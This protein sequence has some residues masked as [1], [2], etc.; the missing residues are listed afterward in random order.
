MKGTK[1]YLILFLIIL[2]AALFCYNYIFNIYEVTYNLSSNS[3]FADNKSTVTISTI[4]LNA[5]GWKAP[6]RNAP[7]NFEIREGK[8]LVEIIFQNN[9]NGILTLK[10]KNKTGQ[11]VVFVKSKYALLP[12]SFEIPIYPNTASL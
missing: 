9:K 6:L 8:Y 3:L 5:F 2:A 12:S 7:T 11:I 10:A 1:I 4:P